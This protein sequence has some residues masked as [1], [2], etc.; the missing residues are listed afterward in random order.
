M[1]GYISSSTNMI[2]GALIGITIMAGIVACAC[3]LSMNRRRKASDA[4]APAVARPA[5]PDP[6]V[7]IQAE[8]PPAK[9]KEKMVKPEPEKAPRREKVARSEAVKGNKAPGR[10]LFSFL[11]P[12]P[13]VA[14]GQGAQPV[15]EATPKPVEAKPPERTRPAKQIKGKQPKTPKLKTVKEPKHPAETTVQR[16]VP[17]GEKGRKFGLFGRKEA[18]PP[19]DIISKASVPSPV[20]QAP[21]ADAS[22]PFVMPAAAQAAAV[23][24]A[25][26]A[27]PPP[28]PPGVAPATQPPEGIAPG[29]AAPATAEPEKKEESANSVFDLFTDT[30]GEESEISKFAAN[31]DDVSL[32][33]LLGDGHGL[34]D[35][36]IKK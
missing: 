25:A 28:L 32:D 20:T 22:K 29:A 15:A 5:A 27:V 26:T 7:K 19:E 21:D 33:S 2:V 4:P 13:K 17:R 1:N 11:V 35:R 36:L 24:A 3:A 30:S 14:E 31:F 6:A 12:R 23:Q 34:L 9:R 8:K 16:S 18:A 10:S